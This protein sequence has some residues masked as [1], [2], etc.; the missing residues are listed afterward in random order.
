MRGREKGDKET[1]AGGRGGGSY[2]AIPSKSFDS[3]TC[4]ISSFLSLEKLIPINEVFFCV[5]FL[6]IYL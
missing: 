6:G 3:R 2:S 5:P 1:G 4:D